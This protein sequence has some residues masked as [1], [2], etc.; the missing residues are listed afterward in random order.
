[1]NANEQLV[2]DFYSSFAR[3]DAEGMVACYHPNVVF[4]DPVFQQLNAAQAG[5]MWRMLVG[6]STDI[7]VVFS[8]VK[9]DATTGSAHWDAT[10]TFSRTGRKVTNRIDAAFVFQDAKIIKHTD[11]FDFWKWSRQALGTSGLL[12]G[13]SPML[14]SRVRAYARA[15]LDAAMQP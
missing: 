7:T 6:R 11:S 15:S 2:V 5:S 9:A 12:L 1:M 4:T 14:Q 8:N 13:W 10:Y 3:R